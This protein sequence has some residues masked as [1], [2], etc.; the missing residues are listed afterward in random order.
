[1]IVA[2]TVDVVSFAYYRPS[3]HVVI[4]SSGVY[5]PY[6]V[7]TLG[8]HG[9]HTT[10]APYLPPPT[11][12]MTKQYF[13]DAPSDFIKDSS[14]NGNGTTNRNMSH[15]RPKSARS[16]PTDCVNC[17]EALPALVLFALDPVAVEVCEQSVDV[18]GSRR[19]P[20]PFLCVVPQKGLLEQRVRV[21]CAIASDARSM[22]GARRSLTSL[23][24][25]KCAT[26]YR[27]RLLYRSDP[28]RF[29][30]AVVATKLTL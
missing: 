21:L 25:F 7:Q 4:I 3:I 29:A 22:A 13:A 11:T 20:V 9:H 19:V 8:L 24:V 27:M 15:M 1:M 16:S 12:V 10:V 26:K 2:L 14:T 6:L 18:V 28:M 5:V 17:V 23:S 30:P